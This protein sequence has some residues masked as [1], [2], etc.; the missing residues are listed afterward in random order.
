MSKQGAAADQERNALIKQ[1]D[2]ALGLAAPDV[3]ATKSRSTHLARKADAVK[4]AEKHAADSGVSK[5]Q[6]ETNI[7]SPRNADSAK[8]DRC[9]HARARTKRI[10]AEKDSLLSKHGVAA[11]Q[12]RNALVK[13]KDESIQKLSGEIEDY[14]KHI[15]TLGKRNPM[16]TKRA[17]SWRKSLSHAKSEHENKVRSLQ[18]DFAKQATAACKL[19]HDRIMAEKESLLSK[20]GEAAEQE[21]NALIRQKGR[22][23]P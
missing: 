3:G 18:E 16:S 14:K 8:T 6:K 10:V 13:Q 21:R 9:N 23:D 4:A 7:Q 17:R 12:E 2:D 19:E 15:E 20:H 22:I 5:V 11:E 1:K